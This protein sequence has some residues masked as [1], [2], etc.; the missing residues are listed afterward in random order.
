MK[1][2]IKLLEYKWNF[3]FLL[4]KKIKFLFKNKY[5]LHDQYN[6]DLEI[7]VKYMCN[8]QAY[9]KKLDSYIGVKKKN[10]KNLK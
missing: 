6:N 3:A 7:L 10:L 4:D 9:S 8:Q 2:T 5:T 1:K